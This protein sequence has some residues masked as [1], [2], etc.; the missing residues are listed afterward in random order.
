[1]ER[2]LRGEITVFL[3]LLFVLL[4]SFIGNMVASADLQ[5]GKNK[6]RAVMD[7]AVYSVFGE[8]QKELL[9]EYEIFAIEG[10]YESGVFSEDQIL[11]RLTYYGADSLE[12]EITGIRYLTDNRGQPFMEQ[13]VTYM[14]DYSGIELASELVG[15]SQSWTEQEIEGSESQ[16]ISD[17]TESDLEETL[18]ENEAS[19]PADNNPIQAIA[20][21]KRSPLL[22]LI[23]PKERTVSSKAIQLDAVASHRSLQ[24]GRG[25]FQVRNDTDSALSNL[26][27]GEYLLTKFSNAS[28]EEKSAAALDYETE[29]LIAGKG[30]DRENLEA[31]ARRILLIRMGIN[32]LYLQTDSEKQAE[33]EALAAALAALAALPIATEL[34][35]QAVL[36][37]WAYGE[38]IM[39]LRKL[40][41][42]N[43]TP[44][45]K[46]KETWQLSLFSLTQLGTAEDTGEGS[47]AKEGMS[48]QDYLRMLLFLEEKNQCS[49]R[50]LD[51]I[52][53][54]MQTEKGLTFFR[55]DQCITG[56][57]LQSRT[58][59]ERGITYEFPT[60]FAYR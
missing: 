60:C 46:T 42:G 35:K 6:R 47:H 36:A 22:T 9:E 34:V 25:T 5:V 50:A 21:A 15:S 19:L 56:L 8:Y 3:S 55:V 41:K 17:R 52:E 14:K 39:D 18:A 32:F 48:Y 59:F 58:T 24:T 12:S 4:V 10:S 7:R 29:Y 13:V 53:Q 57:Q 31:V 23:L 38:S 43:K 11:K 54:N 27:F 37:A 28:K 33:A 45:I 2:K 1:M 20:D 44:L 49:M 51:L 26:L 40:L 30:S 16:E